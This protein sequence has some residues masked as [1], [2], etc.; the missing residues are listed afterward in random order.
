MHVPPV[1]KKGGCNVV[2]G[3]VQAC[4]NNISLTSV[5][6][7]IPNKQQPAQQFARF[8]AERKSCVPSQVPRR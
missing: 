7:V 2:G 3:G 8:H 4:L 5:G 6:I 1:T